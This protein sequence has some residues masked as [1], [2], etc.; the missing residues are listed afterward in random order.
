MSV[1]PKNCWQ[2][3]LYRNRLKAV[4]NGGAATASIKIYL[5]NTI[6]SSGSTILG[7]TDPSNNIWFATFNTDLRGVFYSGYYNIMIHE[8]LHVF[9]YNFTSDKRSD[10]ETALSSKNY[11]LAYKK[12]YGSATDRVYGFGSYNETN[13]CFFTK[14]SRKTVMEDTSETISIAATFSAPIAPMTVGTRLREKVKF[15]SDTFA[16]EYETFSAFVVGSM[17]FCDRRL[18]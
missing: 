14:Y 8:F 16:K 17:L 18:A 15:I 9:H 4:G 12:N 5:C 2:E 6:K 10:F 7:L 11:G 13:S 1:M 3:I